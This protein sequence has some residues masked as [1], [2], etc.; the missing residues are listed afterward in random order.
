MP[1]S[2]LGNGE[3]LYFESL[4]AGGFNP[5]V[6]GKMK[7]LVEFLSLKKVKK[8]QL[9]S[10][11]ISHRATQF[12]TVYQVVYVINKLVQKFMLFSSNIHDVVFGNMHVPGGNNSNKKGISALFI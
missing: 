7:I 1:S 6:G 11:F 2:E 10:F 8:N 4:V 3:F 12:Y 9:N 5:L